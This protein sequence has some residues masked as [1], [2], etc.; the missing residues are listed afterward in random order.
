MLLESSKDVIEKE[1][2]DETKWSLLK[3]ELEQSDK[4]DSPED[5]DRDIDIYRAKRAGFGF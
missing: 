4:S 1:T 3:S 5:N 2:L